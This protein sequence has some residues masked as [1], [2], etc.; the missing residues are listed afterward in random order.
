MRRYSSTDQGVCCRRMSICPFVH[1]KPVLCRNQWT[2]RAGF[3]HGGFLLPIPHCCVVRKFGYLK[4]FECFPLGLCPKLWTYKISPWQL[5]RIVNKT[6]RRR[7]QSSLLTTPRR[8]STGLFCS[9]HNFDWHRTSHGP[10]VVA[11]LHVSPE[12]VECKRLIMICRPTCFLV[13]RFK[14]LSLERF[15]QGL[16]FRLIL[17]LFGCEW[18]TESV[19]LQCLLLGRLRREIA[20]L[21]RQRGNSF[22]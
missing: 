21:L 22:C 9:W 7:R 16:V 6:R 1:H 18:A 15:L 13:L 10:S 11:E 3:W 8:Q 2:N 17:L 20:E 5:D 12:G 19:C 4:K 14:C